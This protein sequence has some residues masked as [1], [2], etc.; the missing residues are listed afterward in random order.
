MGLLS[1]ALGAFFAA[2]PHFIY[3]PGEDAIRIAES[4]SGD[5]R[6][7]VMNLTVETQT[8]KGRLVSYK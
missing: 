8:E 5:F 1:A 6:N 4:L 2:L 3:G 7:A